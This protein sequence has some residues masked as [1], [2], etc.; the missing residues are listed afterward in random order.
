MA[1]KTRST[2][3]EKVSE[4]TARFVR[5]PPRKARYVADLI[6]GKTVAEAFQILRFT[7]RPSS[8]PIIERLLKSAVSGV[9]KKE[10]PD[11]D[12][13]IIGKITVDGG[14][15]LKRYQPR[16]MGRANIIRK[17]SSHI[18]ITLMA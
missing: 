12:V 14:P 17:R 13:L 1:K 11:T 6:R 16:A 10:H 5:V 2:T 9:D 8:M 15:M 3:K 7:M 18:S 4:A